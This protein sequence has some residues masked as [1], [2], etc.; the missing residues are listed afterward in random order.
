[1]LLRLLLLLL[2][3]YTKFPLKKL[4][5]HRTQKIVDASYRF[6]KKTRQKRPEPARM[7]IFR[8]W[9]GVICVSDEGIKSTSSSES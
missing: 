7:D 5:N 2:F 6:G 4:S 3:Y 8:Y 1:M 9:M